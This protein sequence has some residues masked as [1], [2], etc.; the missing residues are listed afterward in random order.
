M[1]R[2]VG[3]DITKGL[4]NAVAGNITKTAVA[5]GVIYTDSINL[6]ACPKCG[7]QPGD[8]CRTPKG[9]K[10]YPPHGERTGALCHSPNHDINDYMIKAI[11]FKK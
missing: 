2:T 11:K 6:V 4:E 3:K 5:T 8:Y 1:T 9:R 10:T 7:S